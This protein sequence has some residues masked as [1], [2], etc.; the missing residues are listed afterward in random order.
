MKILIVAGTKSGCTLET[1]GV[2]AEEL[3]KLGHE[4]RV[5]N[6]KGAPGP[7]DF[8]A[9]FAGS[10]VRAG[11]WHGSLRS[12]LTRHA[13]T[14]A[15]K[16]LAVFTVCLMMREPEKHQNT[17]LAMSDDFL[18]KLGLT[19]VSTGLF[20]GWFLPARFG[21]FERLILKMMKTPHGDF[22]NLEAVRAWTRATA[23]KM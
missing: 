3:S 15:G 17:T 16:P 10:G 23:E 21:F 5:E 22:R 18:K 2:I 8:D 20:P 12:W 19:P 14:L 13:K 4:T 6:A 9:V 7:E 1:A 11:K